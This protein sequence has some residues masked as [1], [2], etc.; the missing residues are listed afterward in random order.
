MSVGKTADERTILIFT[1]NGVTVHNE[2]KSL[3]R[4]EP[5]L[6]GLRDQLGCYCIP[7]QANSKAAK[8]EKFSPTP[9]KFTTPSPPTK[10]VNS[11][12]RHDPET[13]TP[14]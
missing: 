12:A 9:T 1:Q 8:L 5:I 4:G 2:H 3:A 11:D 14:W 10:L 13:G 7:L 6:T